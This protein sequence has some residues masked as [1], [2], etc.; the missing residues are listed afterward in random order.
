MKLRYRLFL[1]RKSVYCAFNTVTK[2]FESLKA[3]DNLKAFRLL[4]TEQP[5]MKPLM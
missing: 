3:N 5:A 2:R 1:R 4:R